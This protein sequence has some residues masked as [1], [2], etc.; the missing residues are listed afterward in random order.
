MK[1]GQSVW[2]IQKDDEMQEAQIQ[3]VLKRLNKELHR[4][5]DTIGDIPYIA[6]PSEKP[7][8]ICFDG[9]IKELSG[10]DANEI[11]ADRE[12]WRN[13]IHVD[14]QERVLAAFSRCKD[15][16]TS[17][18]IEYRIIHKDGSLRYVLDKGEP[19]FNDKG[20]VTQVEGIITAIGQSEK[21]ENIP[22]T[23]MSKVTAFNNRK[24]CALQKI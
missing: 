5:I 24:L 2:S 19:V 21:I 22:I 8:I 4:F 23:E 9:K 15:R 17:F 20:E 3:Y 16:G 11:L 18:E 6:L 13:M 14:D 10:Y 7:E 1:K 12:H